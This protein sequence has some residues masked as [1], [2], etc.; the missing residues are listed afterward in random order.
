VNTADWPGLVGRLTT[1][2]HRAVLEFG[3]PDVEPVSTRELW[4]P[5][6]IFLLSRIFVLAMLLAVARLLHTTL[7]N[8][9]TS[10]DST[11]YLNIA[12]HGYAHA[13]PPGHSDIAQCNLGF[14]PLLP[15]LVRVVH[16]AT[17]LSWATAGTTTT[18]LTGL[19]AAVA[20]WYFLRGFCSKSQARRGISLVFFTPG[21]LVLSFVYSEGLIV[22]FSCLALYAIRRR[23][24]TMAG[25][26][27]ALCSLADPVGGAAVLT[28]VLVALLHAWQQRTLRPL[29]AVVTAPLGVLSFFGYLW[30]HT[31]SFFAW[32]HAQRAGW[33]GG[34]YFIGAP[35]AIYS[36]VAHGFTNLNPPVK[37]VSIFAA[38]LLVILF[39]R[40]KPTREIVLYSFTVIF[41]GLLSPVIGITPRLLLR[42]SPFLSTVGSRLN[43]R[44]FGVL[45]AVSITGLAFL[46]VVSSSP[47]WTP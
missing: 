13:I 1:R 40:I 42:G 3:S 35:K 39:W 23:W 17:G 9:L 10:W 16:A 27:A 8:L 29:L 31:G 26:A 20:V 21:A 36:F 14:F 2:L 45:L 7:T 4:S 41:M 6:G 33:Q 22:T 47:M 24:W 15:I 46:I 38:I 37:T 11:W 44:W 19:T 32:F 43:N 34:T 30:R 12:Q 25:V 18:F 28:V 5:V